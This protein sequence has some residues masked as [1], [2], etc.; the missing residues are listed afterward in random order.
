MLDYLIIVL[1][2]FLG[3]SGAGLWVILVGA[4]G[5]TIELW[6]D[7][8]EIMRKKPPPIPLDW[9]LV[10]F[11]TGAFVNHI[12]MSATAYLVGYFLAGAPG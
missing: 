7:L 3:L 10:G 6:F 5:L 2:G 1:V 12:A 8:Y 4:A 11:Y 9:N